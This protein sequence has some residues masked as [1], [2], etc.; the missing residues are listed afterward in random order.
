[1]HRRQAV[2]S[3]RHT[4]SPL[5]LG[6]PELLTVVP[7]DEHAQLLELARD[8]RTRVRY[9]GEQLHLLD[10]A[11][12]HMVEVR[13]GA[14]CIIVTEQEAARFGLRAKEQRP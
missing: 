10:S 13:N 4:P 7:F 9:L 12:S 6:V 3:K 2:N 14:T 8:R 1:M 11:S 5:Q